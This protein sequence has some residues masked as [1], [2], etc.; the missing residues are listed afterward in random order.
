MRPHVTAAIVGFVAACAPAYYAIRHKPAPV[1]TQPQTVIVT[2]G[3]ASSGV[4]GV[5][6]S[7]GAIE[8]TKAEGRLLAAQWGDLDQKEVDAITAAIKGLPKTPLTIFCEDDAKCGD[9]QLAFDNAFETDHWDTK[10]EK[11]LIDDT[12]GVA[13]SRE[14]L[15][16]AIDEATGGRLAVKIIA[17][18][19]P[20]D[21]LVI[22]KK[23]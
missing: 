5:P 13:T 21:V 7:T 11:P 17:K 16:K 2:R 14:D 12:V 3:P 10:L 15:R 19:A 20:F 22:G 6:L 23:K 9:M 4:P 1:I 8:L 18:N